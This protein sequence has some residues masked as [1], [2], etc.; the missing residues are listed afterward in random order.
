MLS[1]LLQRWA[2]QA[3][4]EM[5]FKLLA[6][7]TGGAEHVKVELAWQDSVRSFK[8]MCLAIFDGK[9]MELK[10]CLRMPYSR[11]GI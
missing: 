4:R 8:P 6:D 9:N 11:V 1:A 5:I 3:N 7:L 10:G 2:A